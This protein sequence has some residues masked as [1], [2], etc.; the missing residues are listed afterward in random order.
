MGIVPLGTEFLNHMT[1]HDP[2]TTPLSS[3]DWL[4]SGFMSFG[5]FLKD[6]G[7]LGLFHFSFDFSPSV[8]MH[9]FCLPGTPRSS[10]FHVQLFL[11]FS[12]SSPGGR[13]RCVFC[14]LCGLLD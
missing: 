5:V 1:D 9:L 11:C 6:P 10:P 12:G 13:A 7:G 4:G 3:L 2:R 14:G 8:Q